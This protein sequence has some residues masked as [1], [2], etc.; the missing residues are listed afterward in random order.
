MTVT[1]WPGNPP[2]ILFPSDASRRKQQ[3][4]RVRQWI[5]GTQKRLAIDRRLSLLAQRA[6][7]EMAGSRRLR[8]VSV[9]VGSRL[10]HSPKVAPAL[11]IQGRCERVFKA[12]PNPDRVVA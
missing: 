11:S 3:Q 10:R 6:R 8:Q 12:L 4:F 9:V 2:S 1:R 7:A 5:F